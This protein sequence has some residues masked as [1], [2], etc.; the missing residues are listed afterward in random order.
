MVGPA[1]QRA[2]AL[3][4]LARFEAEMDHDKNDAYALEAAVRLFTSSSLEYQK[5]QTLGLLYAYY[6]GI[7]EPD[8]QTAYR[9]KLFEHPVIGEAFV[10][11][12]EKEKT[13]PL[14]GQE[15]YLD[16]NGGDDE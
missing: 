8:R 5:N 6:S 12:F 15:P 10:A 14:E 16:K 7:V 2:K 3:A 13:R 11:Y 1:A 9:E 4:A